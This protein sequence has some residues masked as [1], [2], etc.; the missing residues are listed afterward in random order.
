M[1]AGRAQDHGAGTPA[2][3]L[4][5]NSAV[6]PRIILRANASYHEVCGPCDLRKSNRFTDT[7][8]HM[9]FFD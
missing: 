8:P 2:G 1:R 3:C 9:I 4:P 7:V 5:G 6:L